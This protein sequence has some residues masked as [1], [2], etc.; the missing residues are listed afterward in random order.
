[1]KIAPIGIKNT[2]KFT[3]NKSYH[4]N[5]T[6][7]CYSNLNYAKPNLVNLQ[8]YRTNIS[9]AGLILKPNLFKELAAT[10]S[11]P[12]WLKLIAR[13]AELYVKPN[14]LRSEF[15]RDYNRI[16]HSDAYNRMMGKTQVFSHPNSD[17]TSTRI[18]H[19][20][21]VSSVAENISDFL[22]LNTKLTRAIATGHDLGHAP[23]GH[24]GEMSINKIMQEQGIKSDC[25]RGSFW[26][27]KNSLRFVDD[28]ETKLDPYGYEKNL[29]L[30]YAVRD[31]IISHCGEV[32]ENGLR[33]RKEYVDLRSIDKGNRVSPYTWEGCVMKISDK[34]AYLG[35]DIEDAINNKFLHPDKKNELIKLV[36]ENTGKNFKE[37]NNTVLINEFISD[38]CANSNPQDGIGFSEKTFKLMNTVKKFNYESIYFAK[39]KVQGPYVNLVINTIFN[40]LNGLYS[41]KNT[42]AKLEK[43]RETKPHLAQSFKDWLIKYSDAAPEER[44]AKKFAN[45][46]IYSI[47]N[48]DD[49]KLAAIEFISSMTDRTAIKS[50]EEIIFF[51]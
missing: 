1:M 27:E 35:K 38:L 40:D 7:Q 36:K 44:E 22:G 41:G 9:F 18:S 4:K 2:R 11:N 37:I 23:F 5:E 42:L 13:E 14:D 33:P 6:A 46:V 16:L 10:E 32:D 50:F 24:G 43:E 31:G 48:Q 17:A 3:D 34:I 49:Y 28:I 8:A 29:D 19:V 47:D 12:N 51:G 30:T 25:W 15:E 21:Q 39:D 20:N 26:H 45:K